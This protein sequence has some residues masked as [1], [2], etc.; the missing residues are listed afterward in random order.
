MKLPRK[1]KKRAK[2]IILKISS[3]I[4]FSFKNSHYIYYVSSVSQKFICK[5]IAIHK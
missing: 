2:K 1:N 5:F 4:A 3:P